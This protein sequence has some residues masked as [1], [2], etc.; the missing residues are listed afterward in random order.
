ML[1]FPVKKVDSCSAD[2]PMTRDIFRAG[3]DPEVM[4]SI[5]LVEESERCLFLEL[6]ED[7][8]APGPKQILKG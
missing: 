1:T 4:E 6:E 5:E 8:E 7:E 2:V 3:S